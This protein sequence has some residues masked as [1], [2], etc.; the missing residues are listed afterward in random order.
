MLVEQRQKLGKYSIKTGYLSANE[1]VWGVDINGATAQGAPK[2]FI[3]DEDEKRK[4]RV[5]G[6]KY[7]F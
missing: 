4:R 5:A 3:D 7:G 2:L 6:W 1:P